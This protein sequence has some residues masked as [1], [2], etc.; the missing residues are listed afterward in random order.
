MTS[1]KSKGIRE[2]VEKLL[3]EKKVTAA[4]LIYATDNA[5]GA[6][7]TANGF[8]AGQP[9]ELLQLHAELDSRR[10]ILMEANPALQL[11]ADLGKYGAM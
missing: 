3:K 1:E 6:S 8:T 7:M 5:D 2:K 10:N 9:L 4:I 11:L